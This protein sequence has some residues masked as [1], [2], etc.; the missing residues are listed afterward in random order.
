MTTLE[1]SFS[2][3]T[4]HRLDVEVCTASYTGKTWFAFIHGKKKAEEELLPQFGS[5][6]CFISREVR[7]KMDNVVR[8]LMV[9]AHKGSSDSHRH[10][11]RHS[12]TTITAPSHKTKHID[13]QPSRGRAVGGMGAGP[14]SSLD[15][16]QPE[17]GKNYHASQENDDTEHR[18]ESNDSVKEHR[19]GEGEEEEE[20]E[21]AHFPAYVVEYLLYYYYATVFETIL[22]LLQRG[23]SDRKIQEEVG[24]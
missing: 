24:Y 16:F 8:A 12:H 18:G 1:T 6:V 4:H 7:G 14:A 20:E 15:F 9:G 19:I 3:I 11:R 5:C 13:T 10:R 23:S 21:D 22:Y 17:A 2:R